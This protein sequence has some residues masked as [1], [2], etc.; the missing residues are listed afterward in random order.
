MALERQ[1][2]V[3]SLKQKIIPNSFNKYNCTYEVIKHSFNWRFVQLTAHFATSRNFKSNLLVQPFSRYLLTY[4]LTGE[5][6]TLYH[7]R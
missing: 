5:F 1:I 4:V 6:Y 3:M 7:V 2:F